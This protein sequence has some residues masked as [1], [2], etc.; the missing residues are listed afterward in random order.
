MVAVCCSTLFQFISSGSAM[1][2]SGAT[3]ISISS[4]CNVLVIFVASATAS[5]PPEL[6]STPTAIREIVDATLGDR[7]E[8]PMTADESLRDSHGLSLSGTRGEVIRDASRTMSAGLA[9]T[10]SG[11]H[12]MPFQS[13]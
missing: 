8:D 2:G 3:A 1:S 13:A 12:R 5:L 11:C 10:V 6:P 4:A 9:R 7:S